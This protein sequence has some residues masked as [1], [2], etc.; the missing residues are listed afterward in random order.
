M[1]LSHSVSANT[2]STQ[3]DQDVSCMDL[4]HLLSTRPCDRQ[5]IEGI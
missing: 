4:S 5:T 1:D 3:D 2:D